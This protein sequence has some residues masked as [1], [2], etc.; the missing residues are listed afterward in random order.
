MKFINYQNARCSPLWQTGQSLSFLRSKSKT[1]PQF[2]QIR[3][4][5]AMLI[6]CGCILKYH[7]L[8]IKKVHVAFSK[9]WTLTIPISILIIK[10][11]LGDFNATTGS[12]QRWVQDLDMRRIVVA[13]LV[14]YHNAIGGPL[15]FKS[16]SPIILFLLI[17][18]DSNSFSWPAV[19]EHSVVV[20]MMANNSHLIVMYQILDK[21]DTIWLWVG[22]Y[23]VA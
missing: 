20:A 7:C 23:L 15:I 10:D 11:G 1:T 9:R 13:W 6:W 16:F 8:D 21:P 5:F 12:F 3:I 4:F 22:R 17:P 18:S 19:T 14:F 2:L